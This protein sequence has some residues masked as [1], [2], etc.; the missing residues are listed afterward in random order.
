MKS[1]ER[2]H[3]KTNEF[4]V[5][6]ARVTEVVATHRDRLVLGAIAIVVLIVAG[7]GYSWF[8]GRTSDQAGALLGAA[9]AT[10]EAPIVPAPTVPGATQQVGTY[11]TQTA[12]WRPSRR[13]S[14]PTPRP[15]QPS[16][17]GITTPPR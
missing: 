15:A 1:G 17:R 5:R 2:H 3:L 12:R 4:A 9:M 8:R 6:V 7:I 10:Y 13:S 16:P 14:T 11:P